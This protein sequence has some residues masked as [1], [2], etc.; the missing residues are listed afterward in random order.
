MVKNYFK[1]AIR[2]LLKNKFYSLLNILGLGIGLAACLLIF[3]YVKHE[4]SYDQFHKNKDRIYRVY[5]IFKTGDG[6]MATGLTPYKMACDLD[7]SFTEI[8]KTARVDFDLQQYVVKYGD[9]KF[10]EE[11]IS[12]TE[13][14]FFSVFSI[15]VNELSRSQ[16]IL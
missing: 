11:S 3:F 9:K 12:S 1:I 8:E 10:F 16:A 15:S 2:Q 14:D 4:L 7:R 5:E 6:T 13:S